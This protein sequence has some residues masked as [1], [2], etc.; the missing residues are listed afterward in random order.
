MQLTQ[1]AA[2]RLIKRFPKRAHMTPVLRELHWL[3]VVK[4]CQFKI[5]VFTYRSLK[6]AAPLF[7]RS[8]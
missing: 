2:A 3:S 6:N 4:L 5:L 8:T 1:H 7:M